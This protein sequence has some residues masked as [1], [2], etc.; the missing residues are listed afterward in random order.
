L[1]PPPFE[2]PPLESWR[3]LR[4]PNLFGI[5]LRYWALSILLHSPILLYSRGWGTGVRTQGIQLELVP[6]PHGSGPRSLGKVLDPSLGS[7]AQDPVRE[8]EKVPGKDPD[9]PSDPMRERSGVN[10]IAS[11]V[12]G[13]EGSLPQALNLVKP[14]YPAEARRSGAEGLVILQVDID[15]TGAVKMVRLVQGLGHGCDEAAEAA[16]WKTLFRPAVSNGFPVPFQG[17]LFPYRFKLDD[18]T[19]P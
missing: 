3:L 8:N 9:P 5:P 18:R 2:R 19:Q 4:S 6:R 11:G 12:Q 16:V 13:P 15:A 7:E 14:D 1:D 10:G 17:L